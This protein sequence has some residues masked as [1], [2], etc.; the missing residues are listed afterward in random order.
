MAL[1][2]IEECINCGACEPE[3]P[4]EA[5]TEGDEFY[6]IETAKCTECV[7][8]FDEPQCMEVCPADGAIIKDPK[9]VETPE[10]LQAKFETLTA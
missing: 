8:H 2:I 5:I 4:N 7:G 1:I 9:N 10:Q 6:E 3:C